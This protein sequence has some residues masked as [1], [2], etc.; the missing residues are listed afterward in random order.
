MA[1]RWRCLSLMRV[2]GVT[3]A[4]DFTPAKLKSSLPTSDRRR[5]FRNKLPPYPIALENDGDVEIGLGRSSLRCSE[6]E[7]AAS[8]SPLYRRHSLSIIPL[9]AAQYSCY[10][11]GGQGISAFS[12]PLIKN[13]G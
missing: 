1:G 6:P 3:R 8:S 12:I 2:I 10:D 11:S 9:G 4:L 5:I 13:H 7:T